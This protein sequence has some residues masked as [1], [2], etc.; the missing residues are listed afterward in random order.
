MERHPD[1]QAVDAL[2]AQA[3]ALFAWAQQVLFESL[4]QPVMFQLGGASL[5]E[6]GYRATGW[7]LVGLLQIAA[8]LLFIAPLQRWWP[9]QPIQ[10]PAAVRTDVFY[11]LIHRLGLLRVVL[12][13]SVEP[14]WSEL[15]GWLA[16]QGWSGVQLDGLVA[17]WWPGVTDTALAS[18][19]VYLVV[20][21]LF[22]YLF[23]RAEHQFN[24]WWA[25]HAVH[26][27]QADLTMWS[28]NRN[29]L[30]DDVIRDGALVLLGHALGVAPGQFV[31]IVALTQLIENL[32]HANT[33][34]RFGA[35]LE[36]LIVS[37]RF[38]RSHH[39]VGTGHES[40][41]AGTLG[42]HN[43]AV[44]FPV[45]DVIFGTARF[46]PQDAAPE[47]CGIRDQQP[48]AGRPGRDYGRGFLA[49]QWLGLLR[50]VGRA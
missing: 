16:V 5:L 30:L 21:D 6:D 25:L 9:A 38:H 26:H 24:G 33:R 41:G 8:M 20:F 17:P 34:L 3:S 11:T 37:P 14:L 12:F 15:L 45:W 47:P 13:F 50:L 28:D 36:R 23:H 43:F 32:S 19:L 48:Q 29:H 10:D 42:G 7:L 2:W 27:S 1:M 22:D 18:F 4:V 39:A 31:A 44:L 40:H 35:V 46:D 49:Q